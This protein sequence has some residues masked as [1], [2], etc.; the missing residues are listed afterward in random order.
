VGA[1]EAIVEAMRVPA[2]D[3][4]LRMIRHVALCSVIEGHRV[5]AERACAAGVMEALTAVMKA[6]STREATATGLSVYD[7]AVQSMEALLVELREDAAQL[8]V[9]AGML[10]IMAREGAAQRCHATVLEAHDRVRA[11]LEATAQE[12]D[13]N[14]AACAG[15]ERCAAARG[16]GRMCA[17]VGCSARRRADGTGKRLLRCGACATSAY[18]GLAHQRE[19]WEQHKTE[20]AALAAA[21]GAAAGSVA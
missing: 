13:A 15:C 11:F 7:S 21:A 16:R 4:E 3:A 5:N 2:A 12:H 20:C 18:C 9:D 8:A 6:S 17:L 10:D 19:H 1:V 14:A